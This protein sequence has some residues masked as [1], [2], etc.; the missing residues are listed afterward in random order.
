MDPVS[1]LCG[2]TA[3]DARNSAI[4]IAR[5]LA[6]KHNLQDKFLQILVSN[7]NS[8][9]DDVRADC[10]AAIGSLGIKDSWSFV[11]R[12]LN[13]R[14]PKVRTAAA[15]ALTAIAADESGLEI[16]DAISRER[17]TTTR[18]AL[19]QV[20]IRLKLTKSVESLIEWL[21]DGDASVRKGTESALRL[22]TGENLG[23][24]REAW[25]NWLKE[26]K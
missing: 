5:R 17:D 11:T 6:T 12:M 20:V 16:V 9:T 2:D 22:L 13:D 21:E 23:Q 10:V 7:L 18:L 14:D 24:S 25:T 8:A 4:Q 15:S 19:L 26:K 3:R 1:D